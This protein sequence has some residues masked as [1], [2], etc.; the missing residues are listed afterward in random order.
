MN[1]YLIAKYGS[2]ASYA[3]LLGEENV[4]GVLHKIVEEE[5]ND[6]ARLSQLAQTSINVKA[7]VVPIH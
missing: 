3:R 5:K 1:H 4:A 6:D 7:K 2:V